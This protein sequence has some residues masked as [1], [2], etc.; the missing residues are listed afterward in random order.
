MGMIP[1]TSVATPMTTSTYFR[2]IHT[3]MR[4]AFRVR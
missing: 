2:R 1:I 4:G 3:F